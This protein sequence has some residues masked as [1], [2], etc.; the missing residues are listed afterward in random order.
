M[1]ARDQQTSTHLMIGIIMA[2][3]ADI[4]SFTRTLAAKREEVARIRKD[5]A[6]LADHS[7]AFKP[8]YAIANAIAGFAATL[9]FDKYVCATPSVYSWSVGDELN[10]DVRFE[11]NVDS[12]KEGPV[13]TVCEFIM[14]FGLESKYTIDYAEANGA[15]RTFKFTGKVGGVDVNVRFEANIND[16]SDAC[17]KV[18][19]GTEIKEV[20]KYE[21]VCA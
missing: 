7:D 1:G 16:G 21:I 3:K 19:V 9:G 6:T 11:G 20:A 4:F 13:P 2:R 15:S 5:V 18:Q 17:R 12:L 14:G 8:A 10:L